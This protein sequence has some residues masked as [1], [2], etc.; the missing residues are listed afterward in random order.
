MKFNLKK[1][2]SK[3]VLRLVQENEEDLKLLKKLISNIE[4]NGGYIELDVITRLKPEL[5][6]KL[7]F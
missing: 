4:S 6:F 5:A 2:K 7:E 3:V 1:E